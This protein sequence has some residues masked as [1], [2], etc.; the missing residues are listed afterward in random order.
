MFMEERARRGDLDALKAF[1][2]RDEP[3]IRWMAS[4]FARAFAHRIQVEDLMQEGW[5][6]YLRAL[7]RYNP[8]RGT[9]RGFARKH[10]RGQMIA[11]LARALGLSD[12]ARRVFHRVVK[13]IG[14][15]QPCDRE[16]LSRILER[17]RSRYP[18]IA[19]KDIEEILLA[20]R[21]VIPILPGPQ[22]DEG[23]GIS[24]ERLAGI[25]S[26]E[27]EAGEEREESWNRIRERLGEPMGR[28]FVVI[29]L[30]REALKW[31]WDQIAVRIR[32]LNPPLEWPGLLRDYPGLRRCF[33]GLENWDDLRKLF[34]QPPPVLTEEALRQWY[35][36]QRERLRS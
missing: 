34:E 1:M 3:W 32:N 29:A 31:Q 7:R 5:S 8:Q 17:V 4:R 2:A 28:K 36:R 6:G 23:W 30:L 25:G 18:G 22:E 15:L 20:L 11:A 12:P 14:D 16:D 33:P 35:K 27:I 26:G 24:E 13:A 19:Q 9:F 10:V 21:P